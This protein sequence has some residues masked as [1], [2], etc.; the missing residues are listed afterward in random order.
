MSDYADLCGY[1]GEDVGDPDAIDNMI[2]IACGQSAEVD[3]GPLWD[4]LYSRKQ[5]RLWYLVRK[6]NVDTDLLVALTELQDNPAIPDDLYNGVLDVMVAQDLYGEISQ[7]DNWLE[8]FS[9][10]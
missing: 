6:D 8:E 3:A 4:K 1:M 10:V 2:D 7:I 9:G 5:K